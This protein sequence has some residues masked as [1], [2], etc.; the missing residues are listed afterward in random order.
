MEQPTNEEDC[1]VSYRIVS[2]QDAKENDYPYYMNWEHVTED[3]MHWCWGVW[4]FMGDT[5]LT[6][7]GEDGGEPEDQVLIRDWR[8]VAHALE[9]AYKDGL[10][11]GV[12]CRTAEELNE[13]VPRSETYTEGCSCM[14]CN[15]QIFHQTTMGIHL[16][17]GGMYLC[18]TCGNKRCP[19]ATNHIFECTGSNK[20]NQPGSMYQLGDSDGTKL[21]ERTDE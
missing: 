12:Y 6:Y 20:P 3:D 8:W 13:L 17:H 10:T 21:A 4:S 2:L 16:G 15:M 19:H 9:V 18:D 11:D 14:D 5:P 7:M 1:R